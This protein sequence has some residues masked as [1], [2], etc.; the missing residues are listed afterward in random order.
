[1]YGGTAQERL[2]KHSA[3]LETLLALPKAERDWIV[4]GS[5]EYHSECI[6]HLKAEIAK[7]KRNGK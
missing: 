3:R 5:V 6:R 2:A 1:M 7:E 4:L